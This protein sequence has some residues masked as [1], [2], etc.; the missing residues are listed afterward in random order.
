MFSHL[1]GMNG[2]DGCQDCP[3]DVLGAL[4]CGEATIVCVE[5]HG[6]DIVRKQVGE[7][8]LGSG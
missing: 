6:F 1:R 5:F 4:G 7:G 3:L 8:D 2:E